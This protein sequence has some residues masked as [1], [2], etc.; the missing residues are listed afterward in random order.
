M[1]VRFHKFSCPLELP[2]M[3]GRVIYHL[4]TTMVGSPPSQYKKRVIRSHQRA[5]NSAHAAEALRQN[6]LLPKNEFKSLT[7]VAIMDK[8]NR[9]THYRLSKPGTQSIQEFNAEKG[10][11]VAL[12]ARLDNDT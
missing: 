6:A 12:P 3:I 9:T 2:S 8:V 11:L 10:C 1:L 7:S 5:E 4:S